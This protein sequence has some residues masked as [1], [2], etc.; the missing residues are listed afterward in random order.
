MTKGDIP[1]IFAI[2][3]VAHRAPWSEKLLQDCLRADYHCRVLCKDAQIVAYVIVSVA[4][5]V[6][7]ILNICVSPP[8]QNQGL[9]K[10]LLQAVLVELSAQS[11]DECLLD[12]R[13]SNTAAIALYE[14]LGFEKVGC[15]P[16]YY[17]ARDDQPCEAAWLYTLKF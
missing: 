11:L 12:V 5:Q 16:H 9:G 2:E 1:A 15:R 3:H 4:A 10:H 6:A 14:G 8:Q 13:P 7:E 17:P